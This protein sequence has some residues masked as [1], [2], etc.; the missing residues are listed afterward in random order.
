[1]ARPPVLTRSAP[2]A[3]PA[4]HVASHPGNVAILPRLA[5]G[6][7]LLVAIAGCG[8]VE[9]AVSRP[10]KIEPL[11]RVSHAM[12]SSDA[13]LSLGRYFEG[14][15]EW[16]KAIDAYRKAI[17][18]DDRN[19]EAYNAL[20]VALAANGRH[21]D[22]EA[23]LRQAVTLAPNRA[24]YHNNLG[25][26]LLL[27][28]NADAAVVA[29]KAAVK[30]DN[31]NPRAATN[32]REA[33]TR[34]GQASSG[35]GVLTAMT[36]NEI[37]TASKTIEQ[38]A[39]ASTS[40]A[41]FTIVPIDLKALAVLAPDETLQF[42]Q[43]G[44]G[45]NAPTPR[46]PPNT[47]AVDPLR[48]ASEASPATR[49]EI[50]NGNG[51]SG[52]AASVARWLAARGLPY[53]RLSNQPQFTQVETL[54]QYREGQVTAAE[55]VARAMPMPARPEAQATPGLRSDVRVLL[56]RDLATAAAC[57]SRGECES[58]SAIASLVIR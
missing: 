25:Y 52:M 11:F 44:Y 38:S 26:A 54:V 21:S 50:R 30:L 42:I 16:D 14:S 19:V 40:T 5:A 48:A 18:T 7:A 2:S 27:A 15:H 39:P 28:G 24:Q 45:A 8:S 1:M 35:S 36:E 51:V 43:V 17:A 53:G 41:P 56:G 29:L 47:P 10:W 12:P 22:A 33:M 37:A 4:R 23:T 13:Y 55:R 49:I 6:V 58:G 20:G 34:V 32:L 9:R 46:T 3:A 57:V 31:D